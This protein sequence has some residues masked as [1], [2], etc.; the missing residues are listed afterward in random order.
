MN[1]LHF[2]YAVTVAE[3]K[4]ISKAAEELFMGQPNLSRAIK[5][6]EASLGIT[7]FKRTSRGIIITPEG[8][9]FLRYARKITSMVNEVEQ[10]YVEGKAHK[11]QFSVC[12]PRVS[13]ISCAFAE[14][15]KEIG[16]S[17][18]VEI[19]YNETNSMNAIESVLC[20]ESG[21][22]IIR[23]QSA[24]DKY[25]KELFTERRIA[26]E[27]IAEPKYMLLIS[28]DSPLASKETIDFEDLSELIEITHSDPYVPS[29]P[30]ID[31]MK[32]ELANY[33]DKRIFIF[34]RASQFILLENNPY[35]FM[36]VSPI[37]QQLLNQHNLIQKKCGTNDKIYKDVLIYKRGYKLSALDSQFITAVCNAKREY[38]D[39]M[40]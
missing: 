37:P 28:K 15:A 7:I 16:R 36:W 4:S 19:Y 23:Y 18:A 20:D 3:T 21:I 13:Y 12:V 30:Q 35:T 5:E 6:L 27:V 1:I 32:A 26:S 29:M 22:G 34:E 38:L 24:F 39:N 40:L 31:V 17:S 14:F 25:F 2:K 9:E 8:E 10:I 11:Q 33:S